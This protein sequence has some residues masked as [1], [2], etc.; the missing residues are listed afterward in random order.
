[1]SPITSKKWAVSDFTPRCIKD[2]QK[3]YSGCENYKLINWDIRLAHLP[4][5]SI[6]TIHVHL[7]LNI[8]HQAL[9]FKWPCQ[10]HKIRP[11]HSRP[12][13]ISPGGAIIFFKS[14]CEIRRIHNPLQGFRC[15]TKLSSSIKKKPGTKRGIHGAGTASNHS[16][17]TPCPPHIFPWHDTFKQ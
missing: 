5:L 10:S 7:L 9:M 14:G 4:K 12:S 17:T 2:R 8:F 13:S 11:N 15:S 3:V 16:I 1:V 6:S